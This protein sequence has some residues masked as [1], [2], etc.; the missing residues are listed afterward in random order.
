V[1]TDAVGATVVV[2][3]VGVV[4]VVVV[5]ATVVVVVGVVGT[6]PVY[7]P[8]ENVR[9]ERDIDPLEAL[10]RWAVKVNAD[11]DFNAVGEPEIN[12]VDVLRETPAG[13]AGDTEKR[14]IGSPVFVTEYKPVADVFC[15]IHGLD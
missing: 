6:V 12:P 11:S 13:N 7:T 3:I 9:L 5:G 1:T 14:V 15:S 4:V 2:V 8:R 10:T